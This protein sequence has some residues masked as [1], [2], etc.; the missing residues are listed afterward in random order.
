MGDDSCIDLVATIKTIHL[1]L[2]PAEFA[3]VRTP[4]PPRSASTR[5]PQMFSLDAGQPLLHGPTL[6][7]ILG[8]TL[9]SG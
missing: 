1:P 4:P 2:I 3:R 8:L 9:S 6:D 7:H 5:S